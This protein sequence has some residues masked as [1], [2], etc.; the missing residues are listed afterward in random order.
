M[1]T[2]ITVIFVGI[3][4]YAV[5][6]NPACPNVLRAKPKLDVNNFF[7]GIWFETHMKDAPNTAVCREY[8]F[9]VTSNGIL[10]TYSGRTSDN[11]EYSVTCSCTNPST[12]FLF[13][14]AQTYRSGLSN[15]KTNMFFTLILT[16]VETDYG[17]Y[18]L[19]HRCMK[20]DEETSFSGTYLILQ[21]TKTGD[22]SKANGILKN[23]KTDL[24]IF[25]KLRC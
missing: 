8:K 21:R 14:C 24:K 10:L 20:Y 23:H 7:K 11:K 5:A 13:K 12:S 18:A 1:K 2:I 22:G 3:L 25:Q 17:D 6:E 15:R 16:V 19:A 4:T 9:E